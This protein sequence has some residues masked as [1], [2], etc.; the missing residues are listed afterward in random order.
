MRILI[1]GASGLIGHAASQALNAAGHSVSR[2]VRGGTLAPGDV[3][4]TPG[5][6][7]APEAL[8]D[9]DAVLHLAGRTVAGR[10]ND[11]VKAEIRDSRVPPTAALAR[12]IAASFK[13]Y[14]KPATFVSASA[15]GFYG[16]RGDEVLTEASS[17]GHGFLPE[18]CRQWEAAT[19]AA[20]DA[21]VRV[22]SPRIGLVLSA[23]GGALAAMLPLFRL[24]LA[25]RIANGRQW[26]SWISIEDMVAILVFAI[27][28]E[29]ARGPINATSPVQLTNAE[30]TRTLAQVLHRPAI[31]PLPASIARLMFTGGA[32]EELMLSSQR[33]AP[34]KLEQLGFKFQDRDLKATLARIVR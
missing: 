17:P 5:A 7:L 33:V 8:K 11:R 24:G 18:I 28:N 25:G 15:I 12:S 10:W 26:W 2:L 13:T 14:G 21:G 30:F 20:S 16:S 1:S 31:F 34:A 4:W 19:A 9:V 29:S 3:Q 22:V 32:A 27:T 23:E 6:E